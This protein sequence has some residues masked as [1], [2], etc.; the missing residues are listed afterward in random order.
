MF[1]LILFDIDGTLIRTGGAGVQAFGS[2]FQEVFGF[3]N[4]TANIRFAGRTDTGL[5]REMMRN[6]GVP[7]TAEN[8]AK[9]FDA[10]PRWLTHWLTEMDGRLCTGVEEFMIHC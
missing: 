4:A 10:Y 5:V 2:V 1:R 8:F 3:E 9:F 6:H 7:E